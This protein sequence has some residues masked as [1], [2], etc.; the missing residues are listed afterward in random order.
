MNA[1][2]FHITNEEESIAF[3][4]KLATHL[5][6][7]DVVGLGGDL[8]AGKTFLSHAICRALGVPQSQP[9]NSPTFTLINEYSCERFPIYHM[10]LYRLGEPDE[11][12]DLGLWEYYDG[13]GI[14]L[15]E[16]FDKFDDLWPEEALMLQIQLGDGEQRI[17]HASGSGRG[18]EIVKALNSA[19]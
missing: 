4:I 10:D 18:S 15:V 1:V 8:G 7:G 3:G 16:W 14:C 13:N 2:K 6:V 9:V 5:K 19:D 12:Y 17:I 11:L